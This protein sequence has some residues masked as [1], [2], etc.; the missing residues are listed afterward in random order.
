MEPTLSNRCGG[1]TRMPDNTCDVAAQVRHR[2]SIADFAIGSTQRQLLDQRPRLRP[3]SLGDHHRE[4]A[5]HAQ[6]AHAACQCLAADEGGD[7]FGLQCLAHQVGIDQV[8]GLVDGAHG[9]PP[10]GGACT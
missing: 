7:A 1:V 6:F 3:C 10:E 5:E 8:R 4:Q 9:F 2:V